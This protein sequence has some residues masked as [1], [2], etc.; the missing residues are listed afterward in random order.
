MTLD[1]IEDELWVLHEY[2]RQT[3]NAPEYGQEHDM[4]FMERLWAVLQLCET[5]GGVNPLECSRQELLQITRQ[6]P[7]TLMQGSIPIGR[8]LLRKAAFAL[9]S[10]TQEVDDVSSVW[11][12]AYSSEDD[13]TDS[14]PAAETVAG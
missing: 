4:A 8:N 2:V 6:V 9:L 10:E 11:R 5:K 13:G 1:L 14:D 7:A 12:N 3:R